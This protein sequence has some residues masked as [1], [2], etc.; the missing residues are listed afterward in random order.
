[1]KK[2]RP[3]TPGSRH[4]LA[5]SFDDITASKPEKSLVKII[6]KTGGRNSNGRTTMRYIGGGH[7]QKSREI[8]FKRN[9]VGVPAT[10]KSI[11]YDRSSIKTVC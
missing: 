8:D 2:L 11:E 7:K 1:M 5:P 9:K 10:V 3:V 4:R 6:K